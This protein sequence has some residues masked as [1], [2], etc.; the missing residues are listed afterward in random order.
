MAIIFI[1]HGIEGNDQNNW[2]PWLK[3]ELE[4]LGHQIVVP[5]LPNPNYPQLKEWLDFVVNNYADKLKSNLHHDLIF[6]GH[7]LGVPFILSLLEKY[8]IKTAFLVAGFCSPVNNKYQERM[9]SFTDNKFNLLKIKKHCPRFIILNS[10][11]DP[12]ISLEKSKELADNLQVKSILIKNGGHLNKKAGF[13]QFPLLLEEIKKG[14]GN[15][16]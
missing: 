7:S 16:S 2:F 15:Y 1:F 12:Y 13:E 10:D 6:I 11:N 3:K 8:S 14:L 9:A 4:L 5:N